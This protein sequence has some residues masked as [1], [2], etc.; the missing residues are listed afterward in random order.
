MNTKPVIYHIPICPFSQRLEILLELKGKRS[1]VTFRVVDITQPYDGD[2]LK[3]IQGNPVLP[4][5]VTP[6][7]KVIRE[8][9]VLME[10]LE[11]IIPEPAVM[12]KDPYRHAIENML[13]RMEGPFVTQGYTYVMNQ[14]E[15]LRDEMKEKLLQQ[16]LLLNDFLDHHSPDGPFLFEEFGWAEAVYTPIFMRFW[17]V[18]Y[19]EDFELPNDKRF[20]RVKQ[21]HDAC[22]AHHAAQQVSKEEIIKLY[23]DYARGAGNGELLPGR[24]KSSFAF[25]PDWRGR[26]WPPKD[27]YQPA[28]TDHELGL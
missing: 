22:F 12:Q 4:V 21:W 8:S 13:V 19:Y 18:E 20:A 1:D 23:Y 27:K 26:P 15:K 14:D 5:L 2:L 7:G 16:Y 10:Y 17:F 11:T 24:K 28:T 25:E 3:L 9:L 6:E